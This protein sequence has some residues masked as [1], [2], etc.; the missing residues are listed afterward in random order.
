MLW[1]YYV[2]QAVLL[3]VAIY[4]GVNAYLGLTQSEVDNQLPAQVFTIKVDATPS[5]TNGEH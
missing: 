2:L 1:G 4:C 3:F 5:K